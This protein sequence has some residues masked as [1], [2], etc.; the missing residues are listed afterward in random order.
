MRYSFLLIF[1]IVL[2][3]QMLV[4][5]TLKGQNLSELKIKLEANNESI[6]DLLEKIQK[7]TNLRFAFK[8]NDI[9]NNFKI[10]IPKAERSVKGLLDMILEE[11]NITYKQIE[12]NIILSKK[13]NLE[14]DLL[15]SATITVSGKVTDQTG[16]PLTGVSVI[17]KGTQ[18]GTTTDSKGNYRLSVAGESAVLVFSYIGFVNKTITVGA[19]KNINVTMQEDKTM[20]DDIV[21]VGYGGVKRK[22]A[23]GA[24]TLIKPDENNRVKATTTSDLLLGKVAGLQIT[25]GSGSPGSSGTVRLRQGASLNASNDPLIVIDGLTEGNLSSVNPDDIESITVLKDASASAIYGARGANGVIIVK[26]KKG[27]SQSSTKF[28]TP[29]VSYRG[30]FFVNQNINVLKVYSAD[31]FRKEYASRGWN[32]TLLGSANTDWQKEVSRTSYTNKHTVS[33]TGAVPYVPYRVS[34]GQQVEVGTLIGSKNN[35]TTITGN[36]SPSFLKNHLSLDASV[37]NTNSTWPQNGGSYVSAALTDPTQPI[38]F[39]YGPATVNGISYP[40]KAFGYFM[41]G[42]SATGANPQWTNNPVASV[43]LPGFGKTKTN[44]LLSNA[45]LSYKIHGFENLTLNASISSSNI[46]ST[47]N[48]LGQDNA[49]NTWSASNVNLGKGGLATNNNTDDTN[50]RY[51]LDYYLNFKKAFGKHDIDFTAGHT[52][53]SNKMKSNSSA[54]TYTDGTAVAGSV[55]SSVESQLTLAS[56]FGR[57][58]YIFN[59]KY[60]ITGTMRADASSR[61]APETRWGYFPS[62]A[63]AWKLNEENFLKNSRI[64]NELKLRASYGITGQQNIKNVYAYQSS[65]YASTSNFQY[66][67]G[68]I[69]YNTYKPSA[70]DRSIKWETTSTLNFGLDYSLLKGRIYGEVDLYSRHTK[71]LLMYDV[72]VAAGSNFAESL[73]QNIGEMS[74][75]GLELAIGLVPI[76]TKNLAW[77]LNFN[78]AYNASKIERLT[79]YD[80]DPEKTFVNAGNTSSNRFVQYHKVGNSPY[81]YYLAKQNYDANGNPLENFINPAYNPNVTGSLMYVTDDT[82]NANKF[83]TKKSSLAPYYGGFSTQVRYKNYDLGVNGHYAFGQYVYWNTMSGGSNNSF[84]DASSQY[85]TNTYVGWAPNW[86]K[87]HYYS[88]YWLFKG[89]YFK[90]DNVMVGYTFDKLWKKG[91]TLRLATGVQNVATISKYPGLDPEVYNGLDGS[92]TPRPRMFMISASVKF[93]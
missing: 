41:Y 9:D 3:C 84:F 28:T 21:V 65:Y 31:D 27:L 83:D 69:F 18:N 71:N 79:I 52:Y 68:D 33:I 35:L 46:K 5:G 32:T 10:S 17:E 8:E 59:H 19:S 34:V 49:P 23:T 6:K 62:V 73:D 77:N 44:T 25:Q 42:A 14:N 88:D 12:N 2:S 89:D 30:D 15:A 67:E 85:P 91:S 24:V 54:V 72:K 70:F 16:E 57:L 64:I 90:V 82:N 40:Q 87:Q 48:Y 55:P 92:G 74:S 47:G 1:T 45:L 37:K 63:F 22:D 26:T 20:L 58:N 50:N 61:F 56:Y 53:E 36:I 75:N 60:L 4:A 86:A 11:Q 39:D 51:V 76:K 81:T 13:T 38:Y 29:Q 78:F 66:R 7:K 80:G 93:N 43:M